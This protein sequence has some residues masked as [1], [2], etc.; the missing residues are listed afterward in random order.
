MIQ[1]RVQG[2]AQGLESRVWVQWGLGAM[3]AKGSPSPTLNLEPTPLKLNPQP[4]TQT[5]NLNPNPYTRNPKQIGA[6]AMGML[7]RTQ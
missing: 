7:S 1:V 3:T 2:R 4:S 6:H 5:L